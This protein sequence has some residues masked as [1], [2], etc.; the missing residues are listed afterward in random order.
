[1]SVKMTMI[2]GHCDCGCPIPFESLTF[3]DNYLW[4][5]PRWECSISMQV[6]LV[7]NIWYKKMDR[8]AASAKTS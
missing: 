5:C 8:N 6:A 3:H 7:R 2:I 4:R 1:M